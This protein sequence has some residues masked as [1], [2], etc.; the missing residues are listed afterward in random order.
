MKKSK[1]GIMMITAM[2]ISMLLIGATGL[3]LQKMT[4]AEIEAL[5]KPENYIAVDTL[6][7]G[8]YR[9]QYHKIEIDTL[10]HKDYIIKF[11]KGEKV[12]KELELKIGFKETK[13]ETTG[14]RVD[15]SARIGDKVYDIKTISLLKDSIYS[16]PTLYLSQNSTKIAVRWENLIKRSMLEVEKI[17]EI[18]SI[19]KTTVHHVGMRNVDKIEVYNED[20]KKMY[21][22]DGVEAGWDKAP[23]FIGDSWPGMIIDATPY[24]HIDLLNDDGILLISNSSG[25]GLFQ[26]SYRLYINEKINLSVKSRGMLDLNSILNK[27]KYTYFQVLNGLWIYRINR[28]N[29]RIDSVEY[30]F[31]GNIDDAYISKFDGGLIVA[32]KLTDG[33]VGESKGGKVLLLDDDLRKKREIELTLQEVLGRMTLSEADS[34]VILWFRESERNRGIYVNINGEKYQIFNE[35]RKEINFVRGYKTEKGYLYKFRDNNG[36]SK[37]MVLNNNKFAKIYE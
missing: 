25:E 14:I 33:Y 30:K 32:V 15:H 11:M 16:N 1:S 12:A 8:I 20:G 36:H 26:K 29:G 13:E 18:D 24:L 10:G 31:E 4:E 28:E 21:E 7:G 35:S 34:G 5:L 23:E 3:D 2:V 17:Y 37:Y 9:M 22:V 27:G 19:M 6:G